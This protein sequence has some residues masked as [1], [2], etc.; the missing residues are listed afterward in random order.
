[1]SGLD[2]DTGGWGSGL[3]GGLSLG[4]CWKKGPSSALAG[5]GE[6][7]PGM[8]SRGDGFGLTI[9]EDCRTVSRM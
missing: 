5:E 6:R 8:G 7:L 2:L 1:M 9:G 3:E 4:T